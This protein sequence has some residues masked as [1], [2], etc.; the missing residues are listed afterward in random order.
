M[1][2]G[3]PSLSYS[4]LNHNPL[5]R[6]SV[7]GNHA[8]S[9]SRGFTDTAAVLLG[10]QSLS[11]KALTKPLASTVH[12]LLWRES[13]QQSSKAP[14]AAEHPR[15]QRPQR[16]F[17][18]ILPPSWVPYAELMRLEKTGGLYGFYFPYLIGIGYA[19]SVTQPIPSPSF[20]LSTGAIFLAWTVLL[21]GAVCTIND[22]LDRE[23]DRKVA[24]CRSRPIARGAVTPVQG[25]LW[26][27]AQSIAAA[28]VATQ[29]PHAT[30]CF[31][32]AIPIHFL[33]SVYPLAK[34]V[35]D[36]PQVVLSIPLAWAVF[37][38]CSSF[39]LDIFTMQNA[40]LT[41]ASACLFAS[42][43]VWIIMLDYVNACQDTA[44]DV[45]AGVR[46]MAVR[47]QNT[48]AFLTVL[49]VA[50]VALMTAAGLL[51]GMSPVYFTTACGGNAVILAAM[52][53]TVDRARSDICAWWFLRGSILVGGTTVIGLFGEYFMK[54]RIERQGNLVEK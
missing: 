5:L 6:D 37:M 19:A 20:V 24:R 28:V 13:R 50:Q 30:Q 27:V 48:S 42:Q 29:L 53:K 47:Y 36:F 2:L 26:F 51:G 40:A 43:A 18:S 23:F 33:L 44:D 34:R 15:Y 21:R 4:W 3:K 22:N 9:S 16:G 7:L 11:R 31:Y 38:S 45:K 35:T 25:H 54:L 41:S 1:V 10:R 8:R 52:V 39:G 49:S 12:P 32:H 14:L 46:S 17:L